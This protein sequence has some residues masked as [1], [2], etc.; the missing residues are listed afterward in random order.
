M[1]N[2]LVS[3]N[4]HGPIRD[5]EAARVCALHGITAA[6]QLVTLRQLRGAL[7]TSIRQLENER[8]TERFADQGLLVARFTKAT[9]DAFLGMAAT[10]AKAA[11][12]GLGA[13]AEK[14]NGLYEAAVPLA[15]AASATAAGASVDYTKAL[16]SSAKGASSFIQNDGYKLLAKSAI[17]KVEVIKGAMNGDQKEV[18]KSAASYLYDLHVELAKMRG[19]PTRLK[20]AAPVAEIAKRAFEYHQALGEAF[21]EMLENEQQGSERYIALRASLLK[22]AKKISAKIAELERYVHSCSSDAQP[23]LALP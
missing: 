18:M 13:R 5:P 16:A 21:D 22:Q 17:V 2:R 14:I 12:P 9:C 6:Q 4:V 1:P 3:R 10:L 11:L 7:E 23:R 19:M 15:A 20:Q 8:R